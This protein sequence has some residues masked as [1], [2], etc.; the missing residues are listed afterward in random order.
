MPITSYSDY[1]ASNKQMVLQKKTASI[2]TVAQMWSSPFNLAGTPGAGVLAGTDT[3]AGVVPTDATAG[4]PNIIDFAGGAK[5]YLTRLNAYSSVS[6]LIMLADL[7]WKGGA[8][9]FNASVTLGSQPSYASRVPNGTDF[10][11][12]EIFLEAVTAFTGNQSIRIVYTDGGDV[13]RDTGVIATGI[14]PIV[15]RMYRVPLTSGVGAGV[16]R[17]DQVISSVSTVGTFNV[18]VLRPLAYVRIPVAGYSEQRDFLG[19]GAPEVFSNSALI[20]IARPDSTALGLPEW[21]IEIASK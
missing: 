8:Y 20:T 19:T 7:L 12:C 2:T 3:A 6:G 11:G 17:I 4:C 9:A 13:S 18:L 16:K 21:D 14:A 15:G 1:L 5:G 10:T